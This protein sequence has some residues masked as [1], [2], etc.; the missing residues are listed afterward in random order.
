MTVPEINN[1]GRFYMVTGLSRELDFNPDALENASNQLSNTLCFSKIP[2]SFSFHLFGAYVE[3]RPG[4]DAGSGKRKAAS[5]GASCSGRWA[6][7]LGRIVGS[8]I[9]FAPIFTRA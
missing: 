8:T 9:T 7:G 5:S 1:L 2:P 6:L 3:G 4:S